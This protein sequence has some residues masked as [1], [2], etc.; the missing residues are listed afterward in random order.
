MNPHYCLPRKVDA[1]PNSSYTPPALLLWR[2]KQL[3]SQCWGTALLEA[4]SVPGFVLQ[5]FEETGGTLCAER[6]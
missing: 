5:M 2:H 4:S 1:L 3:L 6:S